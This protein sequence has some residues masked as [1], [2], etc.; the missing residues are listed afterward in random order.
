M[1]RIHQGASPLKASSAL[2]S[3]R[4]QAPLAGAFFMPSRPPGASQS[5]NEALLGKQFEANQG[6][7]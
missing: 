5:I 6:A 2:A 4:R 3:Q 1:V 7:A